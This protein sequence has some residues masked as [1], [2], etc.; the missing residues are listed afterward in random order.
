[1]SEKIDPKA[2]QCLSYGLYI[3]SSRLEGK[4][5]G[6]VVN[7]AIQV[8]GNPPCIAVSINKNNLTHEY[9]T[10]SG[11]FTVSILDES[12]PMKFIGLFG[13]RSGRDINKFE[14]VSYK[15]GVYKSPMVTDHT[16][17]VIEAKLREQIDVE[18][19][20]IFVGNV[21]SAEFLKE[22]MPLTYKFYHEVKKGKSP[23]AA[24]TY[25]ESVKS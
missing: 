13:F 17:A 9:I 6:Q 16:L 19:H 23:K 4:L 22:G 12:T 5:N 20:T 21:V 18:T 15:E 25:I 2:L 14:Q 11:I 1:M 8:A 10:K 24:P 7:T 3:V